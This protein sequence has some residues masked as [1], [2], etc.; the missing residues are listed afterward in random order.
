[1]KAELWQ[2]QLADLVTSFT[3]LCQILALNESDFLNAQ[4]IKSFPLRVP[5]AFIANMQVGNPL[6]PLLLQ[7][8]PQAQELDVYPGYSQDPLQELEQNPVPGLLHKYQSR[9]LLTLTGGCAIHCRY[10]FRRHFPYE[11]Q[12]MS[13]ARLMQVIHYIEKDDSIEEVIFSGGD[14]LLVKDAFLEKIISQLEAIP[15]IK[16]LRIHTRL[17]IVLPSRITENLLALLTRSRFKIIMV[18]HC[19]HPNE[20]N[21]SV[22]QALQKCHDHRITLLNQSVLLKGVNDDV[23]VLVALSQALFSANVLPYYLH[24]LDKVNGAAHFDLEKEEALALYAQLQQRISG[25]LVPKLVRE[26]A[27]VLHKQ[28]V[29]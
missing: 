3:E 16:R 28:L 24:V 19:N 17:P 13:E 23:E 27:G 14:P 4:A 10:C 12:I 25:Y 7:V 22:L 9:V 6:D 8:L 18:V 15:H 2:T 5:R 21:T 29:F 1:M 26:V 20:I 11:T